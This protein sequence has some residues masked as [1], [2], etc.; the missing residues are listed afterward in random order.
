MNFQSHNIWIDWNAPSVR[1]LQYVPVASSRIRGEH[2]WATRNPQ[3][4]GAPH[5][6]RLP[7]QVRQPR[8][9]PSLASVASFDRSKSQVDP[10]ILDGKGNIIAGHHRIAA[11]RLAKV[12]MPQEGIQI[13]DVIAGI[14]DPRPW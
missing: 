9:V 2:S 12:R 1:L 10:V 8:R 3:R 6:P 14:R 13:K 11:A 5:V 7:S 4:R